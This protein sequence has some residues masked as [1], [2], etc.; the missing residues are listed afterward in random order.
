MVR[1]VIVQSDDDPGSV[2]LIVIIQ[3]QHDNEGHMIVQRVI[4]QTMAKHMI[5]QTMTEHRI[6]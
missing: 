4:V 1:R 3:T 6:V 2:A 5:V